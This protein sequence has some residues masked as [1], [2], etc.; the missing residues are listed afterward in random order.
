MIDLKQFEF[1][2][3]VG[4]QDLY[5]EE[6]L[7]QV[8]EH[9]RIMAEEFSRDGQLPGTLVL[10]PVATDPAGIRKLFEE[11]AAAPACAGII[12]WMHTFSPSKMWI[13]GLA[14][15]KKPVLHLHTQ[16]NRDIPWDSI[17]MDF[18]NLNQSA[19]GDREHGYIYAR[20]RLPRKVVAGYWQE[21]ELRRRIGVWM[22]ASSARQDGMDSA[23]LRL[24]DNMREVAVTEGDKVEAQIK[25]GW[26]VNTWGIGDLAARYKGVSD[27]AAEK[28]VKDYEAAYEVSP[29]L[30]GPGPRR[31]AV[32][33][34]AKIEIALK[35]FLTAEHAGAFTTTFQDLHGLPQL[36]GL[37]AQRLMEQ[38]YGFGAEGDWKQSML[39]R[40][41]KVMALGLSGGVSFM[42]DYTY[43]FEPGKEAALGAH[44]LEV[45]P[46]IAG[47]KPRL[48]VHPLGIGGKAD[49]ARLVF[50]AAPGPALL[51]TLVDLGT[52][53][54]M[55][56][57]EIETIPVEHHMPRL[58]VACALWK[59]LP[60]IRDAAEAWMLAGGAHHSVYTT[61]LSAEY[62]QDWAEMS[63]IECV[64]IGKD[65]KPLRLREEL[66][67]GEAC[68]K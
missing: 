68:W 65:T 64:L 43:H 62:F 67:W 46:S 66:R 55:I 29:E 32:L 60:N 15:N 53:L 26:Q 17:D 14:I 41:A 7:K 2:F 13:Q 59:P 8:A 37:A 63:Q 48:E 5:G 10:K 23:A 1:W 18:M 54:R 21:A 31:N 36:P 49:P 4:S 11:A 3:I 19:H 28:L 40:A 27:S 61:A 50:E 25:L 51:V 39:V 33:E 35:E 56:V 44:M 58:P 30:G 22:R 16:F 57:N 38:G 34:Q 42:E 52:R 47:A 45:C 20:M 9:A 6:T 12:T 24:G